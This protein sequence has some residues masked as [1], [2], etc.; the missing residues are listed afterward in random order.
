MV[1]NTPLYYEERWTTP[2]NIG[3]IIFDGGGRPEAGNVYY[4]TVSNG[5]LTT[6]AGSWS[7][8]TGSSSTN[9]PAS[10]LGVY[11]I[12]VEQNTPDV[13]G[14]HEIGELTFFTTNT[15]NNVA[16]GKSYQVSPGSGAYGAASVTDGNVGAGWRGNRT[17][18]TNWVEVDFPAPQKVRAIRVLTAPGS[19]YMWTNFDV[20]VKYSVGDTWHV[21]GRAAASTTKSIYWIDSGS[22]L[23]VTAIQLFGCNDGGNN[24][25]KSD[26]EIITEIEAY[27]LPPPPRGTSLMLY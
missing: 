20:R 23:R 6:L 12:R 1:Q 21:L 22:Q 19:S 13:N 25:V 27:D 5:P 10:L 26:N 11:G 15:G 16:L 18:A 9:M 3:T 8:A 17:Y 14:W 2:R 4:T 24:V 7:L